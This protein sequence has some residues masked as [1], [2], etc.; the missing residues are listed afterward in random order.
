MIQTDMM[1]DAKGLACPMPI[2][3]TRKAM[4]ELAPG[5]VMEVQATDKG[6]TAD[7]KAWAGSSGHHYLGTT[8][9][10]GVLTHYLRKSTS[11][12]AEETLYPHIASNEELDDLLTNRTEIVL[13]D[14]REEAEYAF[15][16]IPGAKSVPLGNIGKELEIDKEALIYVICRTGSRSGMA[17]K[18]LT[19]A[20]F[21]NVKNVLPGMNGW[22]GPL[23][24]SIQ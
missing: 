1:V 12:E 23:K 9:E 13:L 4:K 21:I 8:E 15:G 7:L 14:V 18:M 3:K 2:V 16:H 20:G 17:S 22:T 5:C 19:E 24:K 6:S 10:D 11:D